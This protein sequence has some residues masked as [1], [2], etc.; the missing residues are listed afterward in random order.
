[1]RIIEQ[2]SSLNL[3]FLLIAGGRALLI[4]LRRRGYVYLASV[5]A[6]AHSNGGDWPT[7]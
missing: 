1:M 6:P 3:V 4:C 5:Y 7:E 2:N